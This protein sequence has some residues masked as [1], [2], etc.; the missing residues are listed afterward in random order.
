MDQKE[1]G[2]VNSSQMIQDNS[3]PLLDD[4]DIEVAQHIESVANADSIEV[5][6]ISET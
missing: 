2:S 4:V 3:E 5:E 6:Q 1:D